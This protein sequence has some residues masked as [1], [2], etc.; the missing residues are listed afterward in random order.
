MDAPLTHLTRGP[1]PA[2]PYVPASL[3][4][5]LLCS[6]ALQL[7]LPHRRLLKEGTLTLAGAPF[8]S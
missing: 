6:H 8:S 4:T 7:A 2:R 3:R 5:E 1:G